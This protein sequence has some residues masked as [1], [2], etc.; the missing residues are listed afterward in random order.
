MT[1]VAFGLAILIAIALVWLV[2]DHYFYA[3]RALKHRL[4]R[5]KKRRR[6]SY[7]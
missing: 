6:R 4:R 3:G 2:L 5:G 7:Y 1:F